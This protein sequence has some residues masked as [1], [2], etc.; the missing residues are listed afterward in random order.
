MSATIMRVALYELLAS[1]RTKRALIITLVYLALAGLG[2]YVYV[3]SL[4]AIEE[5]FVSAMISQGADAMSAASA[6]T[7]V[8]QEAYQKVIAFFVGTDIEELNPSL[9]GSPL[10]PPFLWGSLLFLP[11]LYHDTVYLVL[12]GFN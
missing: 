3:A 6:V 1:I 12:L 9:I 8:E 5:A 11:F 2:A 7:M 10:L 4:K